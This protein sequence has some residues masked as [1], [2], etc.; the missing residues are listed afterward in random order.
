MG[1]GMSKDRILRPG[2][3][4]IDGVW[5]KIHESM[6][7]STVKRIVRDLKRIEKNIEKGKY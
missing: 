2:D 6:R 4:F 7:L 3:Y 1:D 5:I